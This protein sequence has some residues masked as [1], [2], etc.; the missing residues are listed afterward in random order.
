MLLSILWGRR[1]RILKRRAGLRHS[2]AG[3]AAQRLEQR[4]LLTTST[5]FSSGE[6]TV[7]I[8]EGA[9]SVAVRENP[10]IT[11]RLQVLI[12]G[13]ADTSLP[14]VAV[15]SVAAINITGSDTQ[16]LVDLRGLT[17]AF[18]FVDPDTNLPLQITVDTGNGDDTILA[19]DGFDATLQGGHGADVITAGVGGNLT[20]SGGDG[21]DL[22]TGGSGNDT[23]DAGDGD[24]IV[25]AGAG[26]DLIIGDDG[27]D[28]IDAGDGDDVVDAGTG[29]DSVDGGPGNDSLSGGDGADSL[30]G[31][32]G[33]DT[34]AGGLRNDTLDG[35]FGADAV[36]G[37]AGS[38]S[39]LGGFGDDQIDGGS[40]PDFINGG[41][42]ADLIVGSGGADVIFAG[43]DHDTVFGGSQ[44][45]TISGEAGDD[46]L[47]GQ[48]G[49]DSLDGGEGLDI[50]D[51][52]TGNDRTAGGG[53]PVEPL[54]VLT[55]EDVT[56][57]EPGEFI[58]GATSVGLA[59]GNLFIDLADINGDSI[60][61]LISTDGRVPPPGAT[62]AVTN[63]VGVSFGDG[64][65]GFGTAATF[66]AQN[67]ARDI[68]T[69]DFNRDGRI[70]VAVV[71]NLSNSVS[72]LPNTGGGLGAAVNVGTNNGPVAIDSG[73][74]DGDGDLDII[75][76]NQAA[77]SI[78]VLIFNQ[79]NGTF[80]VT[81]V[82]TGGTTPTGIAL[83]DF[84]GDGDLDAAVSHRIGGGGGGFASE[85]R[86]MINN[87]AGAFANPVTTSVNNYG[88]GQLTA[89]DFDGDGDQDLGVAQDTFIG[90]GGDYLVLSNTGPA[91]F[92][93]T[94]IQG[95]IIGGAVAGAASD[96][97][98]DGDIDIVAIDQLGQVQTFIN[99]DG[100]GVFLQ[101][102]GYS[103]GFNSTDLA[104]GDIDGDTLDDIVVADRFAFFGGGINSLISNATLTD[105]ITFTV[106]LDRPSVDNITVNFTTTDGTATSVLPDPDFTL[107]SGQLLF[108]PG[109]VTQTVTVTIQPD[110]IQDTTQQLTL[111]LSNPVGATIFDGSATGTLVDD[112][113]ILNPSLIEIT[114]VTIAPEGSVD[115]T[116]ATFTVTLTPSSTQAVT[117]DYATEDRTG[118]AGA[119]YVAV[120]GTLTFAP[121]QT[122][123]TVTIPVIQDTTPELTELFGLVLSNVTAGVL[124]G[125]SRGFMTIVDD[126]GALATG[127][128]GDTLRG[129][130]GRDVVTGGR[131]NDLID[132]GLGTDRVFAGDGDDTVFGGADNDTLDGGNH[133]D[134]LFGNG[135]RDT[136]IGNNGDDVI[137]WR[138][139]QD[140]RD[141]YATE[142]GFDT[143]SVPGGNGNN[144][145]TV[146]QEGTD[147]LVSE[148]DKSIRITSDGLGFT[149]GA[150]QVI[151]DGG[152]G[153][154]RITIQ[155]LQNVGFTVV[156]ANGGNGN[157][158]L[159]AAGSNLGSV[160]LSMNG[161]AGQDT[162]SGGL[163]NATILGG[164]GNDTYIGGQGSDVI[165]GG[166]GDDSLSGGLG[167]DTLT[168]NFGNDTLLGDAGN[169]LLDGGFGNDSLDGGDGS[170]T[171][172]G[173][174]DNDALIGGF[175]QDLI[176]GDL[177]QD[178]LIGGAGSDTLDG[179]RDNDQIMGNGGHDRIRG[180]H[181]AD[182]IWAGAGDDTVDGGD[183]NDTVFGMDGN[184]ALGGGDGN[185]SLVGDNGAD[186]IA[187]GDG[188]DSL[189]GGG[190]SDTIVGQD[191][192]DVLGGNGGPDTLSGGQ[193]ADV[194][195]SDVLDLVDETFVLSPAL[196]LRLDASN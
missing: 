148:A 158:R 21:I 37:E 56:L 196:L 16:N 144:D 28:S 68:T 173:G 79:A 39:L 92:T 157:D 146:R 82:A 66:T 26:N 128:I 44:E 5:L 49:D 108:T 194:V 145:F 168:G 113:A 121:G 135:G 75:T 153:A 64:L 62:T 91:S 6:L 149:A 134:V 120:G 46:Q 22:I 98:Q 138:G 155:D 60:P 10:T 72:I 20:I 17:P 129:G 8:E 52:G 73:D 51:G 126:D 132:G 50:V 154:D 103:P 57:T 130:D 45:D 178:T 152:N 116:L 195:A 70:D 71:N 174:F 13:V 156:F 2:T 167:D 188:N 97:E 118:Q 139:I 3:S 127:L 193:G 25:S 159:T 23:I 15:S 59:T 182:I 47:L 186:L 140:G 169:D 38:D 191:G 189:L 19:A 54:P 41:G 89:A 151:V 43:P 31:N 170:D 93:A 190:G 55:V 78:S 179:G 133:N 77:D 163:S 80:G 29:T 74:L 117:V 83:A 166:L 110:L 76:A 86:V 7:I 164:D 61:D 84:D 96:L 87:G 143:V 32:F 141:L 14:V 180:D 53:V 131:L 123:Q 183:G 35:G 125:Q 63:N 107:I 187:G 109:V 137:V 106:S 12:N 34:L 115:Q 30:L 176:E 36:R 90:F 160:V 48:G 58:T 94:I 40:S 65:G 88:A 142:A 105:T 81:N 171:L 122:S 165:D 85:I 42:G 102:A 119:D 162:L 18:S 136:L 150:E 181:G 172:L 147:L 1:G 95:N 114:D 111:D 101:G 184:D 9:D 104:V 27:Q 185:D 11:G 99:D 69:G 161:G 24:D 100:T 175:G 112:D 124:I 4:A 177:G 67:G 33:N 192:N